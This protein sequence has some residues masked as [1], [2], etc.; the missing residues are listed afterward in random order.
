MI[1]WGPERE[2]ETSFGVINQRTEVLKEHVKA[3]YQMLSEETD[4]TPEVFHF[5]NF[6]YIDGKLYYK[7]KGE[8]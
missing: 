4:Q 5:N 6:K 3:L 1:T 7:G 8:P 2:Q